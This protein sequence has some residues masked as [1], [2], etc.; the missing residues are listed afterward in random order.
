MKSILTKP[1]FLVML[2]L[3]Q[4]LFALF[5]LIAAVAGPLFSQIPQ[6]VQYQLTCGGGDWDSEISWQIEEEDGTVVTSGNAPY[7]GTVC[8]NPAACYSIVMEDS[9]GD[10]W[11]GA[12]LILTSP[13]GEVSAF[14]LPAGAAGS[15]PFG[16]CTVECN[17]NPVAVA[18]INGENTDFGFI[19]STGGESVVMGGADYNEEACLDPDVC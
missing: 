14:D 3:G 7:Q 9:W 15:E 18:V 10:G 5:F 19:I 16:E 11:N 2:S 17:F 12:E 13:E 1:K 4:R 6:C 8:L